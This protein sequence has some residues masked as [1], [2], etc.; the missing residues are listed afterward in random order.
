MQSKG[1][2][3]FMSIFAVVGLGLLVLSVSLFVRTNKFL[4]DPQT[5]EVEGIVAELVRVDTSS[6]NRPSHGFVP[7]VAFTKADGTQD[8]Y[9]SGTSSNPPLYE[10]G[11]VVTVLYN[12][13][14]YRLKSFSDLHL[15]SLITGVIG[16]IFSAIGCGVIGFVVKRRKMIERLKTSGTPVKAKVTEIF[17]NTNLKVN[18][19][20]PWKITAQSTDSALGISVFTSDNIWFDPTEFAPIGK[21]V[22]VMVNMAKPKEYW[23]DT[24]F[25]PTVK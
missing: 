22:T 4:H 7:K 13:N 14:D 24:S 2:S 21:E 6:N 12:G 23:M 25:L 5:H 18:G 9:Q 17:Y 15:P 1:L 20:S 11:E 3:V 16:L 19:R 8:F 10:V